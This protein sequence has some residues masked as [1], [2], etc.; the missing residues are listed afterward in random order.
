MREIRADV[1]QGRFHNLLISKN[2][3][4]WVPQI[5]RITFQ[6]VVI[7]AV[8]CAS[9]A[10]KFYCRDLT[11]R[12]SDGTVWPRS[13]TAFWTMPHSGI[14]NLKSGREEAVVVRTCCNAK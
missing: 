5:S 14:L 7:E 6:V 3:T 9:T 11:N 10:W 2:N 12:V 13:H 1:F 4:F 8:K